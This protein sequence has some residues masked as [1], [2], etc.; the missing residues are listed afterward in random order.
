MTGTAFVQLQDPVN[1]III[2][3]LPTNTTNSKWRDI[4][5]YNNHAFI[6]SEAIDHGLQVFDLMLLTT[7]HNIT[8]RNDSDELFVFNQTAHLDTFGDSHNIAI[9]EESGYAYAVGSDFCDGGLIIIDISDPVN[10]S[11]K[12]TYFKNKYLHVCFFLSFD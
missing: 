9:N 8:E 1:P 4:K 5:V 7:T 6:V 11:C 12:F 2:G 3:I 10:P